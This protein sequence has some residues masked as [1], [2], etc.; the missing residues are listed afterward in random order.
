MAEELRKQKTAIKN[1]HKQFTKVEKL[2]ILVICWVHL[3]SAG[4][5]AS[6]STPINPVQVVMVYS[7]DVSDLSM[8]L[9]GGAAAI[10]STLQNTLT[11]KEVDLHHFDLPCGNCHM[12]PSANDTSTGNAAWAE[13]VDVNRSCTSFGCHEY[14]EKMNHPLDV[15][16]P[17]GAASQ[18]PGGS[19]VTC[20]S[21]HQP[22]QGVNVS[23]DSGDQVLQRPEEVG[24][25]TCHSR[26]SGS[27]RKQSHW[28]FSQKAHLVALV[29]GSTDNKSEFDFSGSNIDGESSTCLSCHDEVTV[30]IPAM[31]ETRQEKGRRFRSM[32][33]HPIG[34]DFNYMLSRN[35]MYFN[36][37]RGLEGRIRMFDGKVGCGSCHSLYSDLDAKLVVENEESQLCHTCHNR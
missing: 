28:K 10:S 15:P 32:T 16:L 6:Q 17:A 30:T 9:W 12:P 25:E 36:S 3:L 22:Q 1:A 8:P 19:T 7:S 21:C 4:S 13:I 11:T 14:D 26:I 18:M 29:P 23:G 35:S 33:D 5:I 2:A 34:M 20:L 27:L 24:C 31:N 37:L